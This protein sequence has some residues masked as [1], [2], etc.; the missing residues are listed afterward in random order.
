M[1]IVTD[2]E[3]IRKKVNKKSYIK[4]SPL[5]DFFLSIKSEKNPTESL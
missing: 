5:G 3:V 1:D 4:K 2:M